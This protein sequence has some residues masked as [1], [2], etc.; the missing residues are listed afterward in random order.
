M[1]TSNKWTIFLEYAKQNPQTIPKDPKKRAELYHRFLDTCKCNA[2]HE[3]C[4]VLGI[5]SL[6]Q[7]QR[8]KMSDDPVIL[9]N[10]VAVFEEM[11]AD[12]QN[13]LEDKD[14]YIAELEAFLAAK[15]KRT[16]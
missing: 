11:V 3:V 4:K 13:Q 12:L 9:K 2:E 14:V 15:K 8:F 1:K 5:S 10:K 6:K 16:A 7:M